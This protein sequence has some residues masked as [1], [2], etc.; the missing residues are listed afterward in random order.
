M[1]LQFHVPSNMFP[2]DSLTIL[3]MDF[4]YFI[5]AKKKALHNT[6][7]FH[8][9]LFSNSQPF[10]T[11]TPTFNFVCWC[12]SCRSFICY[13][14]HFLGSVFPSFFLHLLLSPC[15]WCQIL[16]C[17]F[18]F[19]TLESCRR[20][21]QSPPSF[22]WGHSACCL[23]SR[24][25]LTAE[26][27]QLYI[28]PSF[29]DILVSHFLKKNYISNW[30]LVRLIILEIVTLKWFSCH[31][32][33]RE[34]KQHVLQCF[35]YVAIDETSPVVPTDQSEVSSFLTLF[36]IG[37]PCQVPQQRGD[38]RNGQHGG[39]LLLLSTMCYNGNAKLTILMCPKLDWAAMKE[40][41]QLVWCFRQ[42]EFDSCFGLFMALLDATA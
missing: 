6:S 37:S 32:S 16:L 19:V 28:Q 41:Y 21:E 11:H 36:S 26:A 8:V 23:W 9:F 39:V 7:W 4:L 22:L 12:S 3:T 34:I 33:C 13:L 27:T 2:G 15:F 30:Y 1:S 18:F 31:L 10:F 5:A 20:A 42:L 17:P 24:P 25:A 14:V 29:C 40:S 38:E 35:L